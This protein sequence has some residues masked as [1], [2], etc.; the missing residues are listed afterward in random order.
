MIFTVAF[1]EPE[2][3][4]VFFNILKYIEKHS[5]WN[6]LEFWIS[7]LFSSWSGFQTPCFS[8]MRHQLLMNN[9]KSAANRPG[10][11]QSLDHRLLIEIIR[12]TT[13]SPVCIFLSIC[14]LYIPKFALHRRV[15]RLSKYFSC[16]ILERYAPE[17]N[18]NCIACYK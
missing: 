13:F 4:P 16:L 12:C 18:C 14:L 9:A 17:K 2:P 10:R 3:N 1:V 11:I 8:R 15:E 7:L 5:T 6:K